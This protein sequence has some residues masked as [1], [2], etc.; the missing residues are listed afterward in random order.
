M[1]VDE[2]GTVLIW[3]V[4]TYPVQEVVHRAPE[5]FVITQINNI[6][7]A[8]EWGSHVANPRRWILLEAL[9]RLNVV[10]AN[11]GSTYKSNGIEFIIVVRIGKT[12]KII[13][14]VEDES[15]L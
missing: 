11:E 3:T 7:T 9:Y 10:L 1:V 12:G 14:I 4:G 13:L 15:F 8:V 2:A 5:S 6:Y